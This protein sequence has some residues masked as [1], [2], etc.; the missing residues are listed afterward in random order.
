MY[1]NKCWSCQISSRM[2]FVWHATSDLWR[3]RVTKFESKYL[4]T[5]AWKRSWVFL[6]F[7]VCLFCCVLCLLFF[8]LRTYILTNL[9]SAKNCD[10]MCQS[11]SCQLLHKCKILL[12]GPDQTRQS[13]RTCRIP[14]RTHTLTVCEL[15]TAPINWRLAVAKFLSPKI[16][17]KSRS[18][19]SDH[20]HLGKS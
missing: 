3:K 18:R 19:N 6:L 15:L 17:N 11:K 13:P 14:A 9:Y 8:T 7:F 2:F 4:L 20:A 10:A 12:Y 16:R 5:S 1:V